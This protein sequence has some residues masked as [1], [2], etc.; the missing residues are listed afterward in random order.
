MREHQKGYGEIAKVLNCSKDRVKNYCQ[1]N[2]L[3]GVRGEDFLVNTAFE[4]FLSGFNKRHGDKFK[5]VSGYV[6]SE[7]SVL[8]ECRTCTIQFQRNAQIARKN[9]ELTCSVCQINKRQREQSVKNLLITLRV[10]KKKKLIAE[11][12]KKKVI[13]CSECSKTFTTNHLGNKYCSNVCRKKHLNRAKELRRRVLL[14][15][16]KEMDKD[17]SLE[18]L[19]IR[20]ENICYL[21]GD[22]CDSNDYT[23]NDKGHYISGNNHPSIDH[24]FPISK[25]GT[26]TWE[27]IRLAHH[28]C[29]TIKRDK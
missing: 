18:R 7:S 4:R 24:V 6:N 15:S 12:Q 10:V 27:N 17:I 16:K 1:N 11:K 9:K 28:Y 2:N 22:L 26:H 23:L 25:G 5:Y 8:I 21:C 3:N 13:N 19:V 20:D 29:N 14:R